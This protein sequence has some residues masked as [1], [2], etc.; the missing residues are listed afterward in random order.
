MTR[1]ELRKEWLEAL[2]SEK[3]TQDKGQLRSKYGFCCFGVLCEVAV[4]HDLL[5]RTDNG[6]LEG[7]GQ[8]IS[9]PPAHLEELVSIDAATCVLMRMNDL[10]N[11]SFSEIADYLEKEVFAQ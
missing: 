2:R 3:Y 8:W 6:Y 5:K 1:D 4:G 10:E 9:N 7:T 11:K